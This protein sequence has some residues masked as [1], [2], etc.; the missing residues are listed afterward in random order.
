MIYCDTIQSEIGYNMSLDR[1]IKIEGNSIINIFSEFCLKYIV[2]LHFNYIFQYMSY[3][4]MENAPILL[5]RGETALCPAVGL[6]RLNANAM[7]YN[8]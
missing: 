7:S 3:N 4:M 5:L 1:R 8:K 6:Y 2:L